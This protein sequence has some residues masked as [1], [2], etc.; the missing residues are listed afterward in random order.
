MKNALGCLQCLG[1]L[2]WPRG[3]V[4]S[5]LHKLQVSQVVGVTKC[6]LNYEEPAKKAVVWQW[7]EVSC[8]SGSLATL[9]VG[10]WLA[11]T[12]SLPFI[13]LWLKSPHYSWP[14]WGPVLWE[15]SSQKPVVS[16]SQ[17]SLIGG[18]HDFHLRMLVAQKRDGQR[19]YACI[20]TVHAGV[21]LSMRIFGL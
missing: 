3:I 9:G 2:K 18:H 20:K 12:Q 10:I 6:M 17:S 7:D 8:I 14:H 19:P 21:H 5:F 13:K 11:V 1:K 16:N 4:E 15:V